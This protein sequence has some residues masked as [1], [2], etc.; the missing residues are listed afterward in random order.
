M[1]VA[2]GRIGNAA[3]SIHGDQIMLASAF[4]EAGTTSPLDLSAVHQQLSVYVDD[5]DAHYARARAEGAEILAEPADQ[6]W[7]ARSY[8][9]RDLE[10]HQ[11]FFQQ[12]LRDVPDSEAAAEM[13]T[14]G[15][16]DEA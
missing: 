2:D 16:S 4:E 1:E 13:R 8:W 10:G 15:M 9:V 3:L 12:Q 11:W 6:F 14:I 7:G 5:V